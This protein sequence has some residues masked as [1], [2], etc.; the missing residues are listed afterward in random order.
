MLAVSALIWRHEAATNGVLQVRSGQV[1]SGQARSGQVQVR[2]VVSTTYYLL[3]TT[4][5]RLP[6]TDYRLPTT[7]K[8]LLGRRALSCQEQRRLNACRKEHAYNAYREEHLSAYNACRKEHAY[9]AYRE[10]HLSAY[11]MDVRDYF[12][13]QKT[14]VFSGKAQPVTV[15]DSTCHSSYS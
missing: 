13:S 8:A 7:G 12:G 5:Y 2:Y 15:L 4:Y 6:T 10:E 9:N 14:L 3:P 11:K 1:R